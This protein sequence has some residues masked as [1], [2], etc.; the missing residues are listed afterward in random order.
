MVIDEENFYTIIHV[1]PLPLAKN[2]GDTNAD[3]RPV[4]GS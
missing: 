3:T 2:F 1:R 4:C